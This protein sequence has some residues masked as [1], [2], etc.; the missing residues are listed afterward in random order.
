MTTTM[1]VAFGGLTRAFTDYLVLKAGGCRLDAFL[2]GVFLEKTLTIFES[3]LCHCERS[4]GENC[5]YNLGRDTHR[6]TSNTMNQ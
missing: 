6:A 1:S 3:G 2:C 5:G 4:E